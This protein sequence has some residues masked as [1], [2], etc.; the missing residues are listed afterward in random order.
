MLNLQRERVADEEE[1]WF[2]DPDG[3][4]RLL[5]AEEGSILTQA[6]NALKFQENRWFV[7]AAVADTARKKLQWT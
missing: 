6:K 4:P 5:S 3:K 2:V 1:I 7:P